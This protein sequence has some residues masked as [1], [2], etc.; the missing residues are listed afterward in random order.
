MPELLVVTGPP[1]AGKSTVAALLAERRDPSALVVGDTFFAFLRRGA[2]APWRPEAHTQNRV[3]LEAAAAAT[4]HLVAGGLHVVYD[5]VVGPWFLDLF[6][7]VVPDLHYAVLLPPVE[8]CVA[9]VA[10]RTGH[11]FTDPGAA[12]RMHRELATSGI[13]ARHPL[14]DAAADPVAVADVIDSRVADG[15][16]RLAGPALR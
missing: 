15:S 2:I 8:T 4:T 1:G 5:G 16:L 11:G 12:R 10:A 3:V 6:A 13:A 7:E 14:T 9:R